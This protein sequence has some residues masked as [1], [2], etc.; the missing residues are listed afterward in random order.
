MTTP[1]DASI[2]YFAY[3][4]LLG[5]EEMTRL[6]PS[7]KPLGYATLTDYEFHLERFGPEPNQGG[8]ALQRVDG[9]EVKGVLYEVTSDEWAHLCDVS[10]VGTDYKVISVTVVR[11]DRTSESVNTLTIRDPRGPFRPSEEYIDKIVNGALSSGL[12]ESYRA[13]IDDLVTRARSAE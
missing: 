10:G 1:A 6:C 11:D 12:P 13:K 4:T 5:V 8:C 7:A 3:G 9:S 2:L